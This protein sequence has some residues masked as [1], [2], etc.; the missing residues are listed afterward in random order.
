MP[1]Y[2]VKKN[3]EYKVIEIETPKNIKEVNFNLSFKNKLKEIDKNRFIMGI[4][5]HSSKYL[6]NNNI[7]LKKQN[8]ELQKLELEI[9]NLNLEFILS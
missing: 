4:I 3:N 6:K 9:Q 1:I 7:Y 8:L 5:N 2:V